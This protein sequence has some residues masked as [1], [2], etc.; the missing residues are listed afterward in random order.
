MQ[1]APNFSQI[2]TKLCFVVKQYSRIKTVI[3][4]GIQVLIVSSCSFF[5]YPKVTFIIENVSPTDLKILFYEKGTLF[6]SV[7]IKRNEHYEKTS[8]FR[9]GNMS[10]YTPFDGEKI[11]SLVILFSDGKRI[12]Q[13]CNGYPL[14]S[15]ITNPDCRPE[16]NLM[17]FET[18]TSEK[19]KLRDKYTKTITFEDT[20]YQQAVFP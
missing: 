16:K 14:H 15:A 2:M 13:Y 4:L 18:G 8:T 11:D 6:D 5:V 19:K 10:E 20:D 3:V 9:P 12:I 7:A 17:D 1:P